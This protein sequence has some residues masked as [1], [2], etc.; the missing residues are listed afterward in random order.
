MSWTRTSWTR[1]AD[2]SFCLPFRLSGQLMADQPRARCGTAL[3]V[4]GQRSPPRHPLAPRPPA[5]A[6]ARLSAPPRGDRRLSG[7]R[8]RARTR[9]R[10]DRG[11]GM[12]R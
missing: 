12:G 9:T 10:G 8:H 11:R 5:P 3:A 6:P 4:R 2:G 1:R 7:L